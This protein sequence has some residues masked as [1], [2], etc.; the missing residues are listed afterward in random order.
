M[1]KNFSVRNCLTFSRGRRLFLY[2]AV[3][4]CRSTLDG[5]AIIRWAT[6]TICSGLTP[7]HKHFLNTRRM[8][9]LVLQLAF[10]LSCQNPLNRLFRYATIAK[11]IFQRCPV[12][13][14][15]EG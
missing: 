15:V 11:R 8:Y 7:Y 3:D 9:E 6:T 12:K 1:R 10:P 2:T 13:I 4:G 5:Y 14:R